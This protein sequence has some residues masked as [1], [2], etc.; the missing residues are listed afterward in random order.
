MRAPE[1]TITDAL[2][3]LSRALRAQPPVPCRAIRQ[4]DEVYCPRRGCG[5]RWALDE[6]RPECPMECPL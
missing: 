4:S 6:D 2:L 1:P 3:D 5:L